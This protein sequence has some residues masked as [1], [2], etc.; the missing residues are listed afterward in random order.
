MVTAEGKRDN[1]LEAASA[2]VS[3]YIIKPFTIDALQ[4]KI[5]AIF[6]RLARKG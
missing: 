1:V 4:V 5:L 3:Q 2:G 6:E